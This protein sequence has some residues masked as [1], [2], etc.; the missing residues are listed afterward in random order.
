M[1][2]LSKKGLEPSV[3]RKVGRVAVTKVPL[4]N[5]KGLKIVVTIKEYY[6]ATWI[7]CWWQLFLRFIF[8]FPPFL[9]CS[10]PQQA[11]QVGEEGLYS[12]Q[13]PEKNLFTNKPSLASELKSLQLDYS[14][15]KQ[16]Y[17][18]M[19]YDQPYLETL[20]SATLPSHPPRVKPGEESCPAEKSDRKF[21][22]Q[23]FLRSPKL[24][25]KKWERGAICLA[26]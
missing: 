26:I 17:D 3:G 5:L 13:S 21:A 23:V 14:R 19:Q 18:N 22:L 16:S 10:L 4:S 20:D 7:W 25:E 12:N 24:L 11:A 6:D 2:E 9:F 15:S 8:F 1:V